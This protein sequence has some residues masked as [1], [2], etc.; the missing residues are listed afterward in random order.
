M[1]RSLTG[2]CCHR[3]LDQ[4]QSDVVVA[5]AAVHCTIVAW[6]L[7]QRGSATGHGLP[8]PPHPTAFAD[9]VIQPTPGRLMLKSL[10]H[11]IGSMR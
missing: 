3:E 2:S 7:R 10:Q 9:V 1:Q 8:R 5:V 11:C 6:A 4:I